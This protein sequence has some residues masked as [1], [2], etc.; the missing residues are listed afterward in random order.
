MPP[1]ELVDLR[2]VEAPAAVHRAPHEAVAVDLQEV[3]S[4]GVDDEAAAREVRVVERQVGDGEAEV[5]EAVLRAVVREP[6][7]LAPLVVDDRVVHVVPDDLDAPQVEVPGAEDARLGR[8]FVVERRKERVVGLQQRRRRRGRRRGRRRDDRGSGGV[9][10]EPFQEV[11][12]P[13]AELL[14][15]RAEVDVVRH[16]RGRR[17]QASRRRRAP[18]RRQRATRGRDECDGTLHGF[19]YATTAAHGRDDELSLAS[20]KC[21]SPKQ[22]GSGGVSRARHA[23]NSTRLLSHHAWRFSCVTAIS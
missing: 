6:L 8:D 10:L 17:R 19:D 7:P 14:D 3:A 15:L 5:R 22:E 13:V 2:R 18:R 16:R 23:A 12:Q 4:D 11:R 21:E 20:S 9:L 1:V